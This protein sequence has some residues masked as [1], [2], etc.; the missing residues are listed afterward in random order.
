MKRRVVRGAALITSLW[1]TIILLL[2]GMAFLSL[3]ENDYR[4]AARQENKVKTFYLA[5]AGMEYMAAQR[6]PPP[7]DPA[8]GECRVYLPATQRTCYCV[9]EPDATRGSCVYK[10]TIARENGQVIM[11]TCLVCPHGDVFTWYERK[12]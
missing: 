2:L 4:Y 9:I 10:G 12:E 3:M 7:A 8:T 1:I 6:V 11:R 5:R